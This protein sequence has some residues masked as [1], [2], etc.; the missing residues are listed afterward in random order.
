VNFI[1]IDISTGAASLC[2]GDTGR[3]AT[4][5]LLFKLRL[6]K[7]SFLLRLHRGNLLLKVLNLLHALLSLIVHLLTFMF[8]ICPASFGTNQLPLGDHQPFIEVSHLRLS[9]DEL[10]G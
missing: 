6:R 8:C 9:L 10:L 1:N 5:E 3:A 2:G 7:V 4:A